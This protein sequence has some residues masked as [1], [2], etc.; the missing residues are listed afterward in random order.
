MLF[1]EALLLPGS[2]TC[3][4]GFCYAHIRQADKGGV[5]DS[6]VLIGRADNPKVA[7]LPSAKVALYQRYV[8]RQVLVD[9]FDCHVIDI[10]CV[11][12]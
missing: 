10:D 8:H 9:L 5:R 4:D 7:V 11:L 2:N 3:W 12:G 1:E 6:I